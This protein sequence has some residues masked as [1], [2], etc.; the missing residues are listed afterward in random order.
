MFKPKIS[1]YLAMICCS[2]SAFGVNNVNIGPNWNVNTTCDDMFVSNCTWDIFEN[3]VLKNNNE[4]LLQNVANQLGTIP[5][6][7]NENIVNVNIEN[8]YLYNV[9]NAV[10]SITMKNDTGSLRINKSD[11]RFDKISMS[12]A[13][14]AV[15]VYINN[16]EITDSN[17]VGS[18][19]QPFTEDVLSNVLI[20]NSRVTAHL[21]N[22]K[23]ISANNSYLSSIYSDGGDYFVNIDNTVIDGIWGYDGGIPYLTAYNSRLPAI[24]FGVRDDNNL[25][26]L[27]TK[28]AVGKNNT[29]Y[30]MSF[31]C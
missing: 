8:S 9:N 14:T 17:V 30:L 23:N 28:N 10:E 24:V 22:Y 4:Y 1:K 7:F 29:L 3:N 6:I 13:P 18:T 27:A 25:R 15:P 26:L 31:F 11:V 12:L 2:V 21:K 5:L 20:N 16:L 19:I